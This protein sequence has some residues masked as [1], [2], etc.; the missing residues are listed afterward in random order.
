VITPSSRPLRLLMLTRY[1]RLG[2]S[3]RVR[4]HQFVSY[5]ESAGFTVKLVPLLDDSYITALYAGRRIGFLPHLPGTFLRRWRNL[6]EASDFDL[7]WIE[8]DALPWIPTALEQVLLPKSTPLVLDYDDAV[9]HNYAGPRSRLAQ[10]L[11]RDKI[12]RLMRRAELV[13]AGNKDIAEYAR[14][15]GAKAVEVIPSSV[16]TTRY[17]AR[18]DGGGDVTVVGWIGNPGTSAYLDLVA[19][20]LIEASTQ[21]PFRFVAIGALEVPRIGLSTAVVP[22][23]EE[24][25][26]AELSRIDV[27]IMPLPDRPFERGKS[28]YK[29][30]QYMAAGKPSLASP[31]GANAEIVEHG[32]TGFLASTPQEWKDRLVELLQDRELRARMGW[33]G[34]ARCEAE[35]SLAVSAPRLARL[36]QGAASPGASQLPATGAQEPKAAGGGGHE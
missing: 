26:A 17:M 15:A 6:R 30:V 34:R 36:L 24:T 29:L 2:A 31:V 35:F 33:A 9:Y 20:A 16:D 10:L 32:R 4:S 13:V 12:P 8:K 19:N 11:L 1:G 7:V 18:P 27:G 28:G 5:L 25:E 21:V 22:W 23:T 14:A 3:S